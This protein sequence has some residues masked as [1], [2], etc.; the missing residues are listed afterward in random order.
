MDTKDT[1]WVLRVVFDD[2]IVQEEHDP[3]LA[4]P[5]DECS[6]FISYL[7]TV[8]HEPLEDLHEFV[9]WT[10]T[11]ISVYVDMFDSLDVLLQYLTMRSVPKSITITR[12]EER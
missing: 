2:L 4:F 12:N 5:T 1:R 10:S 7:C 9:D 3:E 11:E 6:Q 8:W